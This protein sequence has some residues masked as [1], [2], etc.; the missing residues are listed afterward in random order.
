MTESLIE[1]SD[2]LDELISKLANQTIIAVDT[3]FFRETTYYPKLALVQIATDSI[4]ACIDPLSFDAKPGLLKIL[5][6]KK[7]TK[8]FHS[9]SQDL[10]V[11]FYYLNEIPKPIYDT[12]IANALLTDT[13]Q[14]GYAALVE[15]ELN[16]H[17]DK[18]QTRTNWLQRPLTKKQIQYAGDDVLYLYKLHQILD[19]KLQAVGR[20]SW[21]EE[22][23]KNMPSNE[24]DFQIEKDKLWR[25]VKGASRLKR[26]QL[27]IVQTIALW[28]EIVAQEEN[29]TRR[30]ILPDDTIIQLA[31]HSQIN[32]TTLTQYIPPRF[33][34]SD[35]EKQR[36]L[37]AIETGQNITEENWPKNQFTILDNTQKTLLK[38]LQQHITLK[39]KELGIANAIL[40]S[41]KDIEQLIQCNT[42]SSKSN[43]EK[44]KVIQGWRFRCIG[45]FLLDTIKKC[46]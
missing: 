4:V 30:K 44:L 9:C 26:N 32:E 46:K 11:L 10:E 29:K 14:I 42:N 22:E 41:K 36:L 20:K 31:T 40:C 39:A 7:I 35:N 27:A 12:Q 18:S 34:I 17:L 45:E 2:A 25:R 19:E 1:S 15:N 3:E 13:H 8:I 38:S 33:S 23:C 21:F 37:I 5:C 43:Q 24:N 6:N 16:I 28:R